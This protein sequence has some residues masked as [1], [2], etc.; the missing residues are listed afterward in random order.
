MKAKSINNNSSD[1]NNKSS[2]DGTTPPSAKDANLGKHHKL[3]DEEAIAVS[4]SIPHS[5]REL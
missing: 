3:E 4:Q 1:G 2:S 5:K